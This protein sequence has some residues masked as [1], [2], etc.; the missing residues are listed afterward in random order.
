MREPGRSEAEQSRLAIRVAVFAGL[1]IV[2]FAVGILRLWQL[3]ILNGDEYLQQANDN[4]IAEIRVQPPRG[5]V[6]DRNGKVLVSNRTRNELRVTPVELPSPGPELKAELRSLSQL[7]GISYR[8][9]KKRL[10]PENADVPGGAVILSQDL[11][12]EK[13]F[14][15]R[16]NRDRFPGV[17]V[18]RVF[19]RDYPRGYLAAH[20]FGN[21]GEVTAEQLELPRYR[22]LRQGDLVGQSGVEY[23]YDRFL[24]GA[25]GA[26]RIQVDSLGNPRGTRADNPATAGQTVR[27]T[28]DSDLQATGEAALGSFGLPGA[29]VAMDPRT[30]EILAMGSTPTFD[31]AIFTRP[32]TESQYQQLT[33]K[34]NDAPLANRAIQ[35]LYPP[36]S[37]FKLIT[38][39]A[40]LEEG[41][42]TPQT[43]VEDTGEVTVDTISFKNAGDKVYGPIDMVDALRV[44]SDV[45]FYKLGLEARSSGDGGQIQD[46]AKLYG[47]GE[48]T[49]IDLPAETEGLVP[50]PKWRNQL[51]SEDLTD[52]PWT[53][54][55]NVNLSVGQGDMQTNPLQM[56]VAY[57]ALANGGTVVT[58]HLAQSIETVTGETIEEILPAAKRQIEFSPGTRETL[59]DGFEQ[60]MQKPTGTAYQVFGNWKIPVAGKT[61]TAERG[62]DVPDQSWFAAMAPAGNP[63]IVVVATI[64]RGGFGADAA[65]PVV[66]RIL[67]AYFEIPQV[68][69]A[70]GR[71]GAVSD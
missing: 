27:L 30:G 37:T 24:R 18:E 67:E 42:I 48:T 21:V 5:K 8:D 15:L 4:R 47:L 57:S 16:E 2:L 71:S 66:A 56:A 17:D 6:V 54:G 62:T 50:N 61:G 34:R 32:I 35:G 46:W 39:T 51:F 20:L 31:P 43:V 33:A 41:L 19:V 22:G 13:V 29:F 60:A 25:S 49:G 55:D 11:G 3:E 9:L 53:D 59:L 10:K 52:R 45:Y 70:V 14:Y 36:A 26:T 23:E 1:A 65:A 58:P 12:L 69:P 40:A 64:E 28:I 7:T 44:S 38:A 63:E 68:P